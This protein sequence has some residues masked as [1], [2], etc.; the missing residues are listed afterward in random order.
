[1]RRCFAFSFAFALTVAA[2]PALAQEDVF[3]P[4]LPPP[5]PELDEAI[6][7]ADD[8]VDVVEAAE[9]AAQ[10][11]VDAIGEEPP[12]EP[13][14]EAPLDPDYEQSNEIAPTMHPALGY[15]YEQ[16]DGWLEQC[17]AVYGYVPVD[18][19]G[20][21]LAS[22]ERTYV[23]YVDTPRPQARDCSEVVEEVIEEPAPAPRAR[24]PDKRIRLRPVK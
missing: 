23:A 3:D 19:C 15:S 5:L 21:Y 4:G 24:Q 10:D 1:M 13:G 2:M 14:F 12:Y 9:D 8:A 16:R 18:T 7:A 11:T 22:Y 20:N 17:R 6:E